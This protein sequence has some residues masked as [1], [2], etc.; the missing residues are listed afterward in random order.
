MLINSIINDKLKNFDY[1]FSI[2]IN[3]KK[4]NLDNVIRKNLL[5]NDSISIVFFIYSFLKPNKSFEQKHGTL[6]C[7]GY[8][9]GKYYSQINE[10][11]SKYINEL[12]DLIECVCMCFIKSPL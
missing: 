8:A 7:I 4:T 5:I 2:L 12:K 11:K 3:L 6:L 10:F 9:I 1:L